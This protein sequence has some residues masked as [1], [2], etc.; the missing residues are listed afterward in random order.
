MVFQVIIDNTDEEN[1]IVELFTDLRSMT[2]RY[3]SLH[4]EGRIIKVTST[5]I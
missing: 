3:N 2:E 1:P 5:E 4:E